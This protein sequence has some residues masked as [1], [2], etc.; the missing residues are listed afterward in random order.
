MP[1][2]ETVTTKAN[3]EIDAFLKLYWLFF[4]IFQIEMPRYFNVHFVALVWNCPRVNVIVPHC[5][6]NI[7]SNKGLASPGNRSL[8]ESMLTKIYVTMS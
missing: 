5:S 4:Q 3:T 2:L 8:P 6:V 7:G 1:F